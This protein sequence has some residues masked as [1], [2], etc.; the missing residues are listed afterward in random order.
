MD[1]MPSGAGRVGSTVR[2]SVRLGLNTPR[3][4]GCSDNMQCEHILLTAKVHFN[5]IQC[6]KKLKGAKMAQFNRRK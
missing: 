3:E 4:G 2:T 5:F 6:R 1:P